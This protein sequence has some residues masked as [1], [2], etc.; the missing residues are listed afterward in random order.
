M[1]HRAGSRT[2]PRHFSAAIHEEP[3]RLMRS[4]SDLAM[5]AEWA[6]PDDFGAPTC[7]R[8]FLRGCG[9]VVVAR[10]NYRDGNSDAIWRLSIQVPP[11]IVHSSWDRLTRNGFRTQLST[12]PTGPAAAR[13]FLVRRCAEGLDAKSSTLAAKTYGAT[14]LYFWP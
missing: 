13:T 10:T 14:P 5:I 9:R 12:A 1:H 3:P 4:V 6:E 7:R 2:T 11:S 8:L